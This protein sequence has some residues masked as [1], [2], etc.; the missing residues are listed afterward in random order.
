MLA[1]GMNVQAT[2]PARPL[3]SGRP[4]RTER[5][6]LAGIPCL[7]ELPDLPQF[8]LKAVT[9]VLHG[10]Y[11]S[12]EGKLGVYAA[13][14][15]QGVA[16]VIPDAALHGERKAEG[17]TPEQMGERNYV[18]TA[19]ARTSRQ[20]PDLIGAL[21]SEL[22]TLP[23]WVVGSS[24]GGYSAQYLAL[25]EKRVSRVACLISAGVWLEPQVTDPEARDYLD[26]C[27]PVEQ[28]RRAPATWLLLQNGADDP[29]FPAEVVER[30]AEAYRQAYAA[31]G[32]PERF[33]ARMY[34]G[35]AHYTS[36]QMRDDAVAF[37]L[38]GLEGGA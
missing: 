33:E 26:R 22:G 37:L 3:A 11:D 1:S 16:V 38:A 36:M 17:L 2:D 10:A 35:V 25:Y 6:V 32:C 21:Q 12:K 7:I 28:A 14:C 5:R 4:Y 15:A 31:A 27:R 8:P 24:M 18:W 9:L 34:P 29:L 30:T 23:V 13:L 19:A 20:L